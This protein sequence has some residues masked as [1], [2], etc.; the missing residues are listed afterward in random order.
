MYKQQQQSAEG[1]EQAKQQLERANFEEM[2]LKI[3]TD[4]VPA[5]ESCGTPALKSSLPH[6]LPH[7]LPTADMH[8]RPRTFSGTLACPQAHSEAAPPSTHTPHT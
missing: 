6:T 4:T 5:A 1:K 7:T 3:G 2:V 8:I